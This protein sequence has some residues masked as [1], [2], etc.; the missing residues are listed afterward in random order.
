MNRTR[1]LVGSAGF[2]VAEGLDPSQSNV[3]GVGAF[4]CEIS[5]ETVVMLRLEVDPRS[6]KQFRIT[7]ASNNALLTSSTKEFLVRELGR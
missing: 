3:V 4:N 5:G 7:V 2:T 6:H 1:A